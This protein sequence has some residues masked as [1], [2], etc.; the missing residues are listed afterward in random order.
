MR[1]PRILIFSGSTRA[2]SLNG[3]LAAATARELGLAGAQVTRISLADYPLPL[4]DGDLE[5][6]SGVPDNAHKLYRLVSEHQG[7]FITCP[8]YNGGYTPLLKN[9]IDWISRVKVEGEGSVF[10]GRIFA[11]GAASP[12]GFGGLRGLLG[13]RPVLEVA[14]GAMVLPDQVVLPRAGQAFNDKG[15]LEDP[16]LAKRLTAVAK[17][18]VEE[19]VRYVP[20]VR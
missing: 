6:Q 3:K 7:V 11:L 15:D 20:D 4:Y 2:G 13:I 1:D 18:I 5:A 12:G 17:R 19:A 16:A 14:L 8:E 10:K 9:T